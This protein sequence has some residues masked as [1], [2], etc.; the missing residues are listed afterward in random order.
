VLS[1][2]III[3][4][5][6]A[7]LTNVVKVYDFRFTRD[8]ALLQLCLLLFCRF[9]ILIVVR[10]WVYLMLLSPPRYVKVSVDGLLDM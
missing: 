4:V 7:A 9:E 6:F 3:R 5:D 8:A 1:K 2:D 10:R